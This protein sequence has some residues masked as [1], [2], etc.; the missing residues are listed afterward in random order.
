M[1]LQKTQ[2]TNNNQSW[3]E[4]K[5][6]KVNE[7]VSH[8]GVIYQNSTGINSNPETLIDWITLQSSSSE[9]GIEFKTE[10]TSISSTFDSTKKGDNS[11][12]PFKN[13]SNQTLTINSGV[14]V[15]NDVINIERRGSGELE[16]I[17]GTGVRFRGVRT[18]DNRFFVGDP[19]T[20]I[21]LICR[22]SET[23]SIIGNLKRGGSA[24]TISAYDDLVYTDVNKSV[25]VYG[26]GFSSNMVVTISGNATQVTPY[27]YVNANQITLHLTS[28]GVAGN[29]INVIYDNG[30]VFQDNNAIV[31]LSSVL[32]YVSDSNPF[33]FGYAL[34]KLTKT[35]IYGLQVRRDS[36]NAIVDVKFDSF[37]KI[38]LSSFV[39]TGVTLGTWAGSTNVFIVKKYNQGT[40]GGNYNLTQNDATKQAKLLNSG[41]LIVQDSRMFAEFDGTNDAYSTIG[42]DNWCA[43]NLNIFADVR[44]KSL[45][46]G[47][48]CG[49]FPNTPRTTERMLQFKYDSTGIISCVAA[50]ENGTGVTVVGGVAAINTNFNT[51]YSRNTTNQLVYI[52]GTAGTASAALTTYPSE[53]KPIE[54]GGLV[55]DL[56]TSYLNG[57]NNYLI[58]YKIDNRTSIS[59]IQAIINNFL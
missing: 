13:T 56:N 42:N 50:L 34:F 8:L 16:I 1:A 19:N 30:D 9:S 23:F 10:I 43:G 55:D 45:V 15:E 54:N 22:G 4:K 59:A 46:S 36:D 48:L 49:F 52:N 57:Y 24:V 2:I 17:Q 29:T 5:R 7:V 38:S 35:Q 41:V 37:G 31:L 6:Y 3:N 14:Y 32:T 21:S 25:N 27:T 12:F 58:I 20:M 47:V 33:A 53:S 44:S 26:T 18:L 28:T 51:V 40:S 39:S 11:L